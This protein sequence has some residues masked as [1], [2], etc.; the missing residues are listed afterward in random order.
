MKKTLLYTP[1]LLLIISGCSTNKQPIK[2]QNFNSDYLNCDLKTLDYSLNNNE[3]YAILKFPTSTNDLVFNSIKEDKNIN[4]E[5]Y[6]YFDKNI[7]F[8]LNKL[9][10]KNQNIKFINE[11][12]GYNVKIDNIN[13][14]QL[15]QL[16]NI[17]DHN[18]LL[19]N[20]QFQ[21][22]YSLIKESDVFFHSASL[23]LSYTPTYISLMNKDGNGKTIGF[24]FSIINYIYT[25]ESGIKMQKLNGY[26][27]N[28]K[29][30]STLVYTE[31][32]QTL[33]LNNGIEL[34]FQNKQI[35]E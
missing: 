18:T 12:N 30:N 1:L 2:D 23:G 24:A 5:S 4:I 33:K 8:S 19:L 22:D 25:N 20:E 31:K 21:T 3:S 29:L 9:N 10:I 28:D 11:I 13:E 14:K 32:E 16:V 27:G 35:M 34:K 15:C 7:L 26:I 6:N 17:Q